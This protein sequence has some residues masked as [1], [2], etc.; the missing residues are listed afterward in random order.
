DFDLRGVASADRRFADHGGFR[1]NLDG[2]VEHDGYEDF[3]IERIDLRDRHDR[4]LLVSVFTALQVAFGNNAI[5][6][7]FDGAKFQD[8]LGPDNL[9]LRNLDVGL[10]FAKLLAR[11][12]EVGL[13]F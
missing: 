13:D 7:A 12:P 5:D 6:R 10:R 8:L 3:D 4:R 9:E 2:C 11:H 1:S